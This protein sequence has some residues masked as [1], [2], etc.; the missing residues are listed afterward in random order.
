M[1]HTYLMRSVLA[2]AIVLALVLVA[3]SSPTPGAP[4][5]PGGGP[6]GLPATPGPGGDTS[7]G[8]TA[9]ESG[10]MP[11]DAPP[12]MPEGYPAR[13][14]PTE[15]P[16]AAGYTGPVVATAPAT[17]KAAPTTPEP[18][19]AAPTKADAAKAPAARPSASTA[20]PKP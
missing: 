18:G 2:A 7:G 10:M 1:S 19:T 16:P 4:S 8:S 3:C 20:P 5:S 17:D 9:P 11:Y 12:N 13:Q 15:V 14:I 6:G